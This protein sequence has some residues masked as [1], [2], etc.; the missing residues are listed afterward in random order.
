MILR[1]DIDNKSLVGTVD[2]DFLIDMDAKEVVFDCGNLKIAKITGENVVGFEQKNKEVFVALDKRHERENH[3]Q[4]AYSGSPTNGILF[5]PENKEVYTVF[6]TSQWMVCNDSPNDRAKFKI[7]LFIPSTKQCIA[8]GT[9]AH[10]S[11][12]GGSTRYSWVQD[13]ESPS[14]TY[15]FAIGSFNKSQDTHGK[16]ILNYYGSGY[17]PEK[18][19][20][21]FQRTGEMVNFF[22]EKSGV[23]YVQDSYSQILI[24]NHYQEMSGFSVLKKSYG[25]LV[26]KDPTETNL[27]S[28]EL[29]HQWWGNMITC[30][31]WNHFWLN[32]GMATFMSAA[33]NEHIFGKEKYESDINSYRKVYE[34]IKDGGKDKALVFSDWSNPTREDRNLVYFKG[35]YV[36]HLL[37]MELGE[38][39]FWDGI[40]FYSQKYFGRS[41]NTL[42]FQKAMEESTGRNLHGFFTKWIYERGE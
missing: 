24:G 21:I 10:T 27:I 9:L 35:A 26:M 14:Y 16:I 34:S 40:K 11:E 6:S 32:E 36:L 5:V 30:E 8:S 42:D 33:F 41:V 18:L 7:D 28:H 19:E 23:P 31:N 38:K 25:R 20:M 39:D 15:G 12:N 3:I 37:R 17:T 2:I 22:E 1:T 13:Y 29:A 4:I